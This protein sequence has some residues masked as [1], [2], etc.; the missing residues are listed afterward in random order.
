MK[1][2]TSYILDFYNNKQMLDVSVECIITQECIR[3]EKN[4]K[5]I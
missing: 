5:E 4:N 2:N 3:Q 1:I